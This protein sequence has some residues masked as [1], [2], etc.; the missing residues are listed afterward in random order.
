M[1]GSI[2][3]HFIVM[4]RG[5]L[6]PFMSRKPESK[7]LVQNFYLKRNFNLIKVLP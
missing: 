3:T 2:P 4:I 6:S 7:K 1:A 5:Q